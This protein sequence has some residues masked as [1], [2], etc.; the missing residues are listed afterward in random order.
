M[1]EKYLPIG[2]I[3]T[4]NNNSK[5]VMIT[6]Y[7][8]LEYQNVVKIYDYSGC[9][10]PE[11]L[12]VKNSVLSFNHS[13][14]G[15]IVDMGYKD[16]SFN[17]LNRNLNNQQDASQKDLATTSTFVNVK[18]D[19]NGVVV[20]D[21]LSDMKKAPEV[22]FGN[23]DIQNPFQKTKEIA[24][25]LETEAP[26]V[27]NTF[28][29]DENGIVIQ[30][31]TAIQNIE[32]IESNFKYTFDANGVVIA[33]ESTNQ[34]QP[35]E[36]PNNQYKFSSD[37]VVIEE[38]NLELPNLN[39]AAHE[40]KTQYTFSPDGTVLSEGDAKSAEKKPNYQFNADGIVIAE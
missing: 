39:L 29:F 14:I 3:V 5:K 24:P 30:D 1:E 2:T 6:G 35:V 13:D 40:K 37:G 7:Y 4:L 8:S 38:S 34:S 31:D 17:I 25:R 11:G 23:S 15:S 36:T 12:L 33:E 21:E 19:A 16:E 18:F 20:Y 28:K 22:V 32:E 10:Y 26:K 9:F 27:A